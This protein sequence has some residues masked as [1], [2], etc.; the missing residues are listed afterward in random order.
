MSNQHNTQPKLSTFKHDNYNN[1]NNQSERMST[2]VGNGDGRASRSCSRDKR[3]RNENGGEVNEMEEVR[4]ELE[5]V[6]SELGQMK[7]KLDSVLKA[8]GVLGDVEKMV[9]KVVER[10]DR[11][12]ER[13]LGVEVRMERQTKELGE[14]REGVDG[15]KESV[16]RLEERVVEQ[17][18][19][20]RR[21]NL[22]FFNV[23]E[24]ERENCEEKVKAVLKE[25]KV[26]GDVVIERA[27]RLGRRRGEAARPMIIKVLD[28]RDKMKI[29]S[30]RRTFPSGVGVEE[31]YP[32]EIREARNSLKGEMMTARRMGYRASII[33]PARLIID[34]QLKRSAY[35]K[36]RE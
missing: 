16:Q 13:L 23:R 3:R 10:L 31:D 34:G 20:Q 11:Q 15:W 8:L 21:N 19:R 4:S 27:H 2:G 22:I 6:R 30:H 9:R 33:Y 26:P 29:L 24:E 1:Y 32:M 7:D 36:P 12:D 35:P 18:A 25:A 28:H 5:E 14:L 17:E